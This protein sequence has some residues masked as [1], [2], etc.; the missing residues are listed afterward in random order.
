MLTL[1][2]FVRHSESCE[3]SIHGTHLPHIVLKDN[4]FR[5]KLRVLPDTGA[6]IHPTLRTM[7]RNGHDS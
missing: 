2:F 5:R 3:Y 1:R 6:S 7:R 4:D